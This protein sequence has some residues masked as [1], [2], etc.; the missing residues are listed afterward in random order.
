[1]VTISV[2]VEMS[3]RSTE[4][5]KGPSSTPAENLHLR[6]LVSEMGRYRVSPFSFES[7]KELELLHRTSQIWFLLLGKDI[8]GAILLEMIHESR[9]ARL[10]MVPVSEMPAMTSPPPKPL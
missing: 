6:E 8:M 10:T 2:S 1:M 4:T 3:S 9:L 5:G 7:I